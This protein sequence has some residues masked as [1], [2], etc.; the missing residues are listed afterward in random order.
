MMVMSCAVDRWPSSVSPWALRKVE[1]VIP[2][3]T[4]VRFMRRAKAAS[5]PEMAS[6]IAVAAS[7]PDRIAP[8]RIR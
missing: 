3:A 7:L 1:R 8:A 4:A 5:D 2:S 6:A